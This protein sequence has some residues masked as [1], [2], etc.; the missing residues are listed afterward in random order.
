MAEELIQLP[1]GPDVFTIPIEN[2]LR[3]LWELEPGIMYFWSSSCWLVVTLNLL[4][5]LLLLCC[6]WPASLLRS[7]AFWVLAGGTRGQFLCQQVSGSVSVGKTIKEK[8]AG[9]FT[10]ATLGSEV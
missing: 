4:P 2:H 9:S 5:S 3:N 10:L 1:G 7:R 6:L 8:P